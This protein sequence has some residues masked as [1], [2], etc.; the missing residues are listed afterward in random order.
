MAPDIRQEAAAVLHLFVWALRSRC[1]FAALL[2]L[3]GFPYVLRLRLFVRSNPM[4]K[5]KTSP[6]LYTLR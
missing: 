4:A 3:L 2:F 5:E 1:F 6:F